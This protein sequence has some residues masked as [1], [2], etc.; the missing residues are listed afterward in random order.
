[1]GNIQEIVSSRDKSYFNGKTVMTDDSLIRTSIAKARD[2]KE[3]KIQS[4]PQG[5]LKHF[6]TNQDVL[7]SIPHSTVDA[8]ASGKFVANNQHLN[9]THHS[10]D[11]QPASAALSP[12]GESIPAQHYTDNPPLSAG[13]NP[14]REFLPDECTLKNPIGKEKKDAIAPYLDCEDGVYYYIGAVYEIQ[15][16][17]FIVTDTGFK[18][19]DPVQDKKLFDSFTFVHDLVEPSQRKGDYM[20]P[21]HKKTR[22]DMHRQLLTMFHFKYLENYPIPTNNQFTSL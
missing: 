1:M 7:G 4:N 16:Y 11:H 22:E 14:N 3:G 9:P 2:V 18:P 5:L 21:D 6:G 10:A 20:S 8:R 13:V 15:N 17:N 19:Y 12:N